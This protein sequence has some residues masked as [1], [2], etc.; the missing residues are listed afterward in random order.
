MNALWYMRRLRRMSVREVVARGATAARHWWWS[1][2]A[3][4][5]DLTATLLPGTRHAHVALP[6]DARVQG[7]AVDA[8]VNAADRLLRGRWQVFHLTIEPT[9]TGTIDW[10]HDPLTGHQA[11]SGTYCFRIPHRDEAAVGN[12]KFVWELSRHQPLTLLACAWW[13]TGDDRFAEC[14]ARHLRSWWAENPFLQGVHWVSGIEVG[15]RLLSWS[16]IRALLADWPGVAALFEDDEAFVPHLYAHSLYLS[17]FRSTGSSANNHLIAELA[18]QLAASVAFPWFRESAGWT[19]SASIGLARAAEAQT[20]PDGWNREQASGYHLFVAEMLLAAALPARLAAR[21]APA[22]EAVLCRML[23]TLAASLDSAGQPPRFGDADDARGVLVDAP[24]TGATS[25]LL[26]A[27][28]AL[29]GAA[30]WW[31]PARNTVLGE[32]TARVAG[33]QPPTRIVPQPSHFPSA[34]VTILRSGDIWLRCDAGPHGHGSIAAHGHADA[35]SIELRCAGVEVLADPGTYCYHGEAAWRG[36]FRG[37]GAHSTLAI[38]EA[39]QAASG[40]PFL[41][42]THPRSGLAEWVPDRAWQASHDGYGT[43]IHHRRVTLDG[44]LV[45]VRDWIDAPTPQAAVLAFHLGPEVHA[46]LQDGMALLAWPGGGARVALPDALTWRV[47]RGEQ[48]PP[49]GWY[50]RGFGQREPANVL[51]GSG[52]LQPGLMLETCFTLTKGRRDDW[53]AR[54]DRR[55]ELAG[56]VRPPGLAGSDDA[57]PARCRRDSHLPEGEGV[58]EIA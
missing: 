4:R 9:A 23:D 22:V 38:A 30:P 27:G 46:E 48:D 55:R 5:P 45:T 24:D 32:I 13:L 33:P 43:T 1:D 28:R 51:A 40:G 41:W 52:L 44:C 42:L 3:R 2:P 14:A 31:P 57:G 29:F 6:R 36:Y 49:F 16:W 26:D 17:V 47:R 37:T 7:P 19:A 58:H 8:V 54:V 18:G 11:P 10:F 20:H 56:A 39:D 15:L 53:T 50:S 34:G 25:A 21:P 35:L 12:I